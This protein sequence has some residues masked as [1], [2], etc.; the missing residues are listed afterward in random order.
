MCVRAL[1]VHWGKGGLSTSSRRQFQ[2][3]SERKSV[4]VRFFVL[5]DCLPWHELM[6]LQDV[7]ARMYIETKIWTYILRRVV[8][9]KARNQTLSVGLVHRR[10]KVYSLIFPQVLCLSFPSCLLLN[11]CCGV[12]LCCCTFGLLLVALFAR[13]RSFRGTR[14]GLRPPLSRKPTSCRFHCPRCVVRLGKRGE[15]Q[16]VRLNKERLGVVGVN[17]SVE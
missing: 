4:I 14:L 2:K 16:M 10:N 8:A 13:G 7:L 17:A 15:H 1:H 11:R 6:E 9:T 12:C 5:Q 3:A